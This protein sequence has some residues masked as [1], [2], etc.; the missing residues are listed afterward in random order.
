MQLP[1]ADLLNKEMDRKD[2]LKHVAVGVVALT[3]ASTIMRTLNPSLAGRPQGSG[4]GSVGGYGY[5]A[6]AY[7]G[8]ANQVSR[9]ARA[10]QTISL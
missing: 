1:L 4:S 5:G 9:P 6:S 3:G 10:A 2:F 8:A 7:G